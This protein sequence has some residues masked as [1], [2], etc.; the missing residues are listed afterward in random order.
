MSS[1]RTT[2]VET[3]LTM[4]ES[5][6]QALSFAKRGRTMAA[7]FTFPTLEKLSP[8]VNLRGCSVGRFPIGLQVANLPHFSS[9]GRRIQFA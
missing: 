8:R 3:I 2:S 9:C 5:A 1:R 4:I 6:R 7:P